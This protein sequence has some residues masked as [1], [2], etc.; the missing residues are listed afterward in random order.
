[1]K[2]NRSIHLQTVRAIGSAA[3]EDGLHVGKPAKHPVRIRGHPGNAEEFAKIALLPY[4][5][6]ALLK[7]GRRIIMRRYANASLIY[8]LV[9]M[10]GGVFYREFTK[11]NGFT[12]NTTLS[13]IHTHYFLLGMVFFLLLLL[14]EKNLGFAEKKTAM[15][16]AVYHAGLNITGAALLVRGVTQTL[17]LSLSDKMDAAISGVS[18]IGHLLL[19]VSVVLLLLLVRKRA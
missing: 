19:G 7:E 5:L 8:A 18:G 13:V 3:G 6:I 4:C 1:M 2:I 12:G 11:F 17:A 15:V 9:A 10:A 14:L 16:T